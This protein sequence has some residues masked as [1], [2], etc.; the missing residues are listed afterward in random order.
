MA[1]VNTGFSN[2]TIASGDNSNKPPVAQKNNAAAVPKLNLSQMNNNTTATNSATN[3]ATNKAKQ[4]PTV[5]QT[6]RPVSRGSIP[7][8]GTK[9]SEVQ[10]GP[11]L[12]DFGL[13]NSARMALPTDHP[14]M[15]TSFEL[16]LSSDMPMVATIPPD[17][18][19]AM[20]AGA[21]D[22]DRPS[23]RR[24]RLRS[25]GGTECLASVENYSNSA[26]NNPT[27]QTAIGPLEVNADGTVSTENTNLAPTQVVYAQAPTDSQRSTG[28]GGRK[29]KHINGGQLN[30]RELA[31]RNKQAAAGSLGTLGKV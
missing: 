16:H 17:I 10:G 29:G 30:P 7:K 2:L 15:P 22:E 18:I 4:Q 25:R 8:N 14:V 23:T 24:S 6:A 5:S 11:R 31:L 12:E 27:P 26:N 1:A 20:A 19:A 9:V 3:N 28:D 13:P 21:T